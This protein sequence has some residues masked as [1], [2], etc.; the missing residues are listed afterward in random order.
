MFSHWKLLCL[1]QFF[2]CCWVL[3]SNPTA[4]KRGHVAES[5]QNWRSWEAAVETAGGFSIP[6]LVIFVI[7]PAGQRSVCVCVSTLVLYVPVLWLRWWNHQEHC[8]RYLLVLITHCITWSYHIMS[9]NICQQIYIYIFFADY[10][11]TLKT[12]L[13]VEQLFLWWIG[14][15]RSPCHLGHLLGHPLGIIG[16]DLRQ[17]ESGSLAETL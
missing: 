14:H 16:W 12:K 6:T 15:H 3:L 11:S 17:W 8:H 7:P 10:S 9:E 2:P 1:L 5:L 4:L 13:K